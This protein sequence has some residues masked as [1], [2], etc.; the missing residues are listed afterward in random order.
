MEPRATSVGRRKAFLL[1]QG[2]PRAEY[3]L[4]YL[5]VLR[6]LKIIF[7]IFFT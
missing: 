3:L 7:L 2:S 1:V 5:R 6:R 4:T